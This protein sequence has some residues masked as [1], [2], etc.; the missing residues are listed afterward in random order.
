MF[1]RL[2]MKT[3]AKPAKPRWESWPDLCSLCSLCSLC[4]ALVASVST[5]LLWLQPLNFSRFSLCLCAFGFFGMLVSLSPNHPKDMCFNLKTFPA[6]QHVV[7]HIS[8]DIHHKGKSR[9]S[10]KLLSCEKAFPTNMLVSVHLPHCVRCCQLQQFAI[11]RK[12]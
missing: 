11:S 10:L 8:L 1:L 6:S 4:I 12:I 7:L 2:G 9:H 5:F 3:S